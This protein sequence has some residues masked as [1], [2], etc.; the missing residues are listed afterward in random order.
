MADI[1]DPKDSADAGE[2]GRRVE[3][4]Q[5]VSS[6]LRAMGEMRALHPESMQKFDEIDL[7]TAERGELIELMR[8]SPDERL[9]YFILG[10]FMLR[11][12]IAQITGRPF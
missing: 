1:K 11:T 12:I 5:Y 4:N 2:A 8:L 3:D 7:D 10:K 9:R 6:L